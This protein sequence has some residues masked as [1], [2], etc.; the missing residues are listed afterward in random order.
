[1]SR[2]IR[3]GTLFPKHLNLNGDQ[4]NLLAL[5]VRAEAYAGNCRVESITNKESL[6]FDL[7]F[8]GHGSKAAWSDIETKQPE[9]I[10]AVANEI[11]NGRRVMAVGSGYLKLATELGLEMNSGEH[12]SE[13]LN[14]DGIVGY[15]NSDSQL[16]PIQRINNAFLTLLHGPLL[17]KNPELADSLLGELGFDLAKKPA[18]LKELDELASASRRIAFEN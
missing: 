6:D 17:V 5:V 13:F 15:V 11:K 18:Y 8:V 4:A 2:A 10:A 9:L 7:I 12:R 14:V 16:E 3:I 1:M